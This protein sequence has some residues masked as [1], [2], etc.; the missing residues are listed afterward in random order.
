VPQLVPLSVYMGLDDITDDPKTLAHEERLKE[1]ELAVSVARSLRFTRL[2]YASL[3]H[4]VGDLRKDA[5]GIMSKGI[6]RILRGN[7]EYEEKFARFYRKVQQTSGSASDGKSVIE[8]REY[9]FGTQLEEDDAWASPVD[10]HQYLER[11]IDASLAVALASEGNDDDYW[12]RD[13]PADDAF[14]EE[15]LAEHLKT[16]MGLE[17]DV[18]EQQVLHALGQHVD[19]PV[20]FSA[21]EFF[22]ILGGA[23]GL[24]K[25]G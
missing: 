13:G 11:P 21:D 9:L 14:Q 7:D 2:S 1:R 3:N 18:D 4:A 20:E 15:D 24:D 19:Q 16:G 6:A 17:E 8:A 12:L 23:P 10:L 25:S 22:R 5:G